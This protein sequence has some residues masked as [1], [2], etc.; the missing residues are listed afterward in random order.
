MGCRL[1]VAGYGRRVRKL[2]LLKQASAV[3][4]TKSPGAEL[5]RRRGFSS[6]P[7]FQFDG[8]ELTANDSR[9]LMS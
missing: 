8:V 5:S 9:M 6:S 7:A 1:D 4:E 3:L 2:V